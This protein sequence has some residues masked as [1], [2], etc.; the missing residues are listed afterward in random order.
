MA[1]DNPYL[2][3]HQWCS[4]R[5]SSV[6]P[7]NLGMVV[8]V[9]CYNE[10]DVLSVLKALS[11]C[12]CPSVAVEVLV[13]LNHADNAPERVKRQNDATYAEL[14]HW[15]EH[16]T[17]YGIQFHLLD[18]RDLPR[19]HAGVGLARK[20]GL[21]EGVARFHQ[22]QREGLLVNLD[23]DCGLDVDYL[24]AIEH[25]FQ[26]Q[27]KIPGAHVYFEHPLTD[28]GSPA[29]SQG[30]LRYELYL[31]YYR[32]ALGYAG[33]PYAFYT[34]GSCMV[35]RSS[36]YQKIG[37]MNRRQ[38]GE[39]F[40]FLQKLRSMG[41]IADIT[42]TVVRPSA[43]LSDRV[44]FGTG[45][46]V[47]AWL[48]GG[49]PAYLT[50]HPKIFVELQALYAAVQ[51]V[52][53]HPDQYPPV[54]ALMRAFLQAHHSLDKAAEIHANASRWE[55]FQKR[56]HHWFN[57]FMCLK[58]IHFAQAEYPQVDLHV[59]ATQLLVWLGRAPEVSSYAGLLQRYREMDRN[60]N[61]PRVATIV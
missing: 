26:S 19:K 52:Y 1:F 7:P 37:G 55:T 28:A 18:Y 60:V 29:Q 34:I 49:S 43:R 31:R 42:G 8:V 10:P 14:T 20:L 59:A 50:Y 51:D 22:V 16:R 41:S 40:Y 17:P 24:C 48:I 3:K 61:G 58:F 11:G 15:I 53:V 45:R 5:L 30:M 32:H 27:P 25:T 12:Q 23:A 6:V 35:V 9:P 56:F 47:E 54:S 2:K 38:A 39:D 57:G 13:V 36:A 33:S 4:S 46:A 44:P 21:D